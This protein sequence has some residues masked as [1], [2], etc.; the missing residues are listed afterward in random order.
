MNPDLGHQTDEPSDLG[1]CSKD[2]ILFSVIAPLSAITFWIAGQVAYAIHYQL[3]YGAPVFLFI[4]EYIIIGIAWLTLRLSNVPRGYIIPV[5]IAII[6][7]IIALLI[8]AGEDATDTY[9]GWWPLVALGFFCFLSI[10]CLRIHPLSHLSTLG[11][12]DYIRRTL[13]VGRRKFPPRR[14]HDRK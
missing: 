5:W 13:D 2:I 3:L 8:F 9:T 10:R 11:P 6:T 7:S 1:C 14:T 4:V 12:L